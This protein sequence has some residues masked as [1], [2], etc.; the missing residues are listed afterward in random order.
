MKR[1]IY[2]GCPLAGVVLAAG[3]S[4]RFGTPK[5]DALL[6]GERLIDRAVRLVRRFTDLVVV[7]L[8][9]GRDWDGVPVH[10]AVTGG[11]SHTESMRRAMRAV[12]PDVELVL[13]SDV[14][15]PLASAR[16]VGD[17]LDAVAS[18]ADAAMPVWSLPDTLKVWHEDSHIT[19]AG[20]EGFVVAQSP[21]AFRAAPL[22]R[23]FDELDEI[24]IEETIG[25]ERIGGRVV[26][27]PG[28]RWSHHVV[29]PR[30]LDL[31]ERLLDLYDAENEASG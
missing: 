2:Q 3:R 7:V 1:G 10:G 21:I 23:M 15:R 16:V 25:I 27:V 8:P 24:P 12:P 13:M 17:L 11:L 18:G 31:M 29:E 5:Q 20:R 28:D 22:R 30:D 9:A 19:H 4:E 14:V 6:G 26:G